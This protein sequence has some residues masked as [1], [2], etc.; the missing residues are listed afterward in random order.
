M[1]GH[2]NTRGDDGW[3]LGEL[4]LGVV[5][6]YAFVLGVR[7]PNLLNA[8]VRRGWLSAEFMKK[9]ANRGPLEHVGGRLSY[10]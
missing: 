1:V 5:F 8:R 7:P 6:G 2:T 4:Q 9:L 10:D 3:A